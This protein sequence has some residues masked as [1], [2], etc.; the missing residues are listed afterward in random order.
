MPRFFQHWRSLPRLKLWLLLVEFLQI[1]TLYVVHTKIFVWPSRIFLVFS[2][3][4]FTAWKSC[5]KEQ[6]PKKS[7]FSYF[8]TWGKKRVEYIWVPEIRTHYQL[9]KGQTKLN[10]YSVFGYQIKTLGNNQS[11]LNFWNRLHQKFVFLFRLLTQTATWQPN[12]LIL[13]F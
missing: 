9:C 10:I 8:V 11:N 7:P 3:I 2:S 6:W 12:H 5:V 1:L 13:T 4:F